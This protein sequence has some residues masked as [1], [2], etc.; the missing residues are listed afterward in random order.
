MAVV[1]TDEEIENSIHQR[2]EIAIE[3]IFKRNKEEATLCQK[4]IDEVHIFDT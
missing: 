1:P 2:T 3:K 4:Y